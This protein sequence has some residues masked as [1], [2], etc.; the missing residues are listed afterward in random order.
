MNI[1]IFTFNPIQENTYV[2]FD[3]TNEAVIIDA[4]CLFAEEEQALKQFIEDKD[5]KLKRILY[6][7]QSIIL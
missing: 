4:G 1:K 6:H 2:L 3:E 7:P 5:L